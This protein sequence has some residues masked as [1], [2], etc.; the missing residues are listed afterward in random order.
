MI[1]FKRFV[2]LLDLGKTMQIATRFTM[3]FALMQGK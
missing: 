3:H 2:R 1:I